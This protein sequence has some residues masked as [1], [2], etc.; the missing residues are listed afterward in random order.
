ME[1]SVKKSFLGLIPVKL[2]IC[3]I[4]FFS[5]LFSTMAVVPFH[6]YVLGAILSV[7]SVIATVAGVVSLIIYWACWA[8]K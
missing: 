7:L 6:D 3:L 2:R 4:V 5:G 1:I 8:E